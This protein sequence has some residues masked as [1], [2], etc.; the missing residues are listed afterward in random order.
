MIKT[1]IQLINF[2]TTSGELGKSYVT[3][4]KRITIA[5]AGEI[6]Q[7]RGIDFDQVLK[8]KYHTVELEIPLTDFESYII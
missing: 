6:L 3:S 5:E 4:E 1:K 8:V 7:E 2:E